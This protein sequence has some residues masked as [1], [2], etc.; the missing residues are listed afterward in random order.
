MSAATFHSAR[1]FTLIELA[2]ALVVVGLLLGLLAPSLTLRMEQRQL[3]ETRQ[4]LAEA[5]EALLGFAVAN[6]RL[7]RPATSFA[8]GEERAEI[9][10]SDAAC[11]GFLPWQTLGT[12]KTDGWGRLI[13]YSVTPAHAD[14]VFTLASAGRKKIQTRNAA[15][16]LA[17]LVGND[18]SCSAANPCAVAVIHSPGRNNWGTLADGTAIGDGSDSNA[19]EDANESAST[20]FIARP[21][22]KVP[23]GGEFDDIVTWLPATVLNG[24]MVAAG[25]LP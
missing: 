4:A 11:T 24:R 23:T 8:N 13:R 16:E 2:I 14:T 17:Y 25:R 3:A 10:L 6:G 15:G 12:K 21:P 19:D 22:G 18:N 1:G 7:P 20:R 9:C 5:Q